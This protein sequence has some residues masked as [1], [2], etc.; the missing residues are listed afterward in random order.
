MTYEQF[1]SSVNNLKAFNKELD[2]LN[3]VLQVLSPS[4]T[5]T[6]EIGHKFIDDYISLIELALG[7]NSNSI[8]WFVF[9]NEFGKKKL[10]CYLDGKEYKIRNEKDMYK[11]LKKLNEN[12]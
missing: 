7:D 4:G 9:D 11:F 8:S 6:C 10:S 1:L 5:G 12:I 2:K 3:D